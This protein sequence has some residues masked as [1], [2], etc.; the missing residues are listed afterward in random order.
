MLRAF[1]HFF[2]IFGLIYS[3]SIQAESLQSQ[4]LE[5]EL[6]Q[7][8]DHYLVQIQR[9]NGG[10]AEIVYDKEGRLSQLE[11]IDSSGESVRSLYYTYEHFLL[12]SIEERN[13]LEGLFEYYFDK[14]GRLEE[15]LS[16]DKSIHYRYYY[17]DSAQTVCIEDFINKK[18]ITKNYNSIVFSTPRDEFN[19]VEKYGNQRLQSNQSSSKEGSDQ[20]IITTQKV[21]AESSSLFYKF[22]DFLKFTLSESGRVYEELISYSGENSD[23]QTIIQT[24]NDSLQGGA[25]F[26]MTGQNYDKSHAGHVGSGE[27]NNSVRLT[28][29]NGILNTIQDCRR[30][31][32]VISHIHGGVNVHYYY[33]ATQGYSWDVLRTG[34]G[35][36]GVVSYD[37]KKMAAKWK[38]L[39]NEMG[40][41]GKGGSIIHYAHSAGGTDTA[42]ALSLL[43]DKERRM[44]RVHTF[45]SPTIISPDETV[46]AHNYVSI[47]DGVPIIGMLTNFRDAVF[48][49]SFWGF[50]FVD[51]L[52]DEGGTYFSIL[53]KQG[54]AF[55]ETYGS[56]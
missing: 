14:Q 55:I 1:I 3:N 38:E 16:I 23:L 37:A 7:I 33:K 48:I 11:I 6:W 56:L 39:I 2:C 49:G 4:Q 8:G 35:K 27:I 9:P 44:I 30:A 5:L 20:T 47:R 26:I 17:D 29:T 54:D 12:V 15:M 28:Y 34:M 31:A 43:S 32:E 53:Q 45:G 52:F 50:P 10:L 36:L 22:W 18:C 21:N 42:N 25:F 24:T 51:H 46:E 19:D 13:S 40:G 41:T